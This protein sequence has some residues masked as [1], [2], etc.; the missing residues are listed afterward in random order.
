[1]SWFE[2]APACAAPSVRASRDRAAI[3]SELINHKHDNHWTQRIAL[4]QGSAWTRPVQAFVRTVSQ[5]LS[6][7]N[8]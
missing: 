2:H 4:L 1:V 5:G 3:D 6:W 8:A 7:N